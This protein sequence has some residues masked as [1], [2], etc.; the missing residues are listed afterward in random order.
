MKNWKRT[1]SLLLCLVV[2]VGL[3]LSLAACGGFVKKNENPDLIT[4]G[5]YQ[6][7]F[8]GAYITKDY[9]GDD[10]I[11]ASFTYTNNSKESSSFMWSMFYT[12]MQGGVELSNSTV[13]KSEDS[14]DYIG[15]DNMK[16]VAPGSSLEVALVYKLNNKTDPVIIN[17]S[18]LMDK[19]T[20]E[21]TI[22]VTKLEAKDASDAEGSEDP[23]EGSVPTPAP[24]G[25]PGTESETS[26]IQAWSGDY[27]GYWVID[28]VW[29]NASDWVKEGNYWDTCATL[30][31]NKDGTG[32]LTIWDEDF[33]KDDPLAQMGITAS[34]TGGV[35]R[36]VCEDGKFLGLPLVHADW[37][38]YTDATEY[39]D[40]FVISG[41]FDDGEDD[42]WYEIYLR[43]WGTDWSD[44]AAN[45]EPIPYYYN[46]W[47]VP[48]VNSG[49]TKAPAGRVA[50]EQDGQTETPTEA[51]TE[52]TTET[53][54][55]AT[56]VD[57]PFE[58]GIIFGDGVVT[59]QQL[60]DF[61]K[62]INDVSSAPTHEE[63]I[64]QMG[65]N[66][67]PSNLKMWKE[68]E[69]VVYYWTDGK[70]FVTV[71]LKPTEDGSSWKYKAVSWT[72]G[73]NG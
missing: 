63:M 72:G 60:K 8:T 29:K 51:P 49:A 45:G 7:L 2:V 10:A 67:H 46:D 54:T 52:A 68:G 70:D 27:Y 16:D 69:Q 71:T 30:E 17:F 19:E 15:E 31:L 22:D 21:I 9:D 37:L 6:A 42:F 73:V 41:Q 48:M 14:F 58:T 47:Y 5:D 12:A 50:G 43:P 57:L 36:F 40:M 59:L 56:T 23:T 24:G 64:A 62:W 11:V 55:E 61:K 28:S 66:P 3:G 65:V 20:G 39:G 34:E 33:P 35:G 1:L 44:V 32:T 26:G 18:D 13:F 38:W 25:D 53:P 4:I